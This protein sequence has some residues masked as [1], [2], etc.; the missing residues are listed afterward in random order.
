MFDQFAERSSTRKRELAQTLLEAANEDG[1]E[2]RQRYVIL[3]TAAELFVEA[4][5]AAGGV[6]V[7]QQLASLFDV[8]ERERCCDILRRTME[9]TLTR[10]KYT[11]IAE[12]ALS[13]LGNAL[14]YDELDLAEELAD[15]AMRSAGRSRRSELRDLARRRVEELDA[16]RDA[17]A[18]VQSQIEILDLL[19][20]DPDANLAVGRFRCLWHGDWE[21]GLPLLAAGADDDLKYRAENDLTGPVDERDELTLGH[22]W[23]NRSERESGSEQD[24]MKR[25]AA[26]WY[27]RALP[28]QTG[29][30][31]SLAEKRIS[32]VEAVGAGLLPGPPVTSSSELRGRFRAIVK[33]SGAVWVNG[34]QI[35]TLGREDGNSLSESMVVNPGDVVVMQVES[36][37]V[38]RAARITVLADDGSCYLAIRR[39]HLKDVTGAP[40]ESI[41]VDTIAGAERTAHGGRP[42]AGHKRFWTKV[43]A[44]AEESEWFFGPKRG[45]F[46]F[47]CVLDS[48]MYR[49]IQMQ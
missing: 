24:E 42:D 7:V 2:P 5:D 1:H 43:A 32:E 8:P 26:Y 25:R 22:M 6:A 27:A 31:R 4:G 38:Y 11:V 14:R 21:R 29:L 49:P 3:D 13:V 12:Q 10:D 30:S 18:E 46:L 33:G 20:K 35:I 16:Y 9:R 44:A 39:E 48:S 40:L 36:R 23:W 45:T 37:F 34:K 28:S 17:Y 41:T 15:M 19:P 47:G